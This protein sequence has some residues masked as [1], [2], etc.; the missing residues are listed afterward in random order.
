MASVNRGIG[1][2]VARMAGN[3]AEMDIVAHKVIA[4][5]KLNATP[6]I[7]TSAYFRQLSVKNVPGKK[8]VRDRLVIAG[9][10]AAMSIEYGHS[11]LVKNPSTNELD[12]R[13]IPGQFILT[14]AIAQIPGSTSTSF[15]RIR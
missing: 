13:W 6:H 11:Q 1:G 15:G 2:T 14:K 5:A 10:K 7:D 8:G 12:F 4:L 9:D 3:H